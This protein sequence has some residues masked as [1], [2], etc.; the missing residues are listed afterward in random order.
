M[1]RRDFLLS[2]TALA[3]SP[4]LS[5]GQEK[6]LA[7]A[8]KGD[9]VFA[10]FE[11]GTYD[12]WTLEGNCWTPEPYSDRYFP[13]KITGYQGK[14]F[15]CT[16]HPTKGSAAKGKAVSKEFTIERPFIN[17]LIGGGN[18]P[19]EAC[20]NLTVDGKIV[21]TVTGDD[22]ATLRPVCWDVTNLLGIRANLEV[23]DQTKSSERGYIMVDN[24]M[25]SERPNTRLQ[26]L[27]EAEVRKTRAE[28][29]APC[30]G[31]A[32]TID[33]HISAIVAEG[34]LSI[35]TG[36]PFTIHTPVWVG[37]VSKPLSAYIIGKVV[38]SGKISFDA[39]FSEI[40]PDLVDISSNSVKDATLGQFVN[41]TSGVRSVSLLD[42][43]HKEITTTQT[44]R[45]TLIR[46][47]L[48][49]QPISRPGEVLLYAYGM[50]FAAAMV[51]KVTGRTFEQLIE[52][53]YGG[54]GLKSL[55]LG[56]PPGCVPGVDTP[57]GYIRDAQTKRFLARSDK[58]GPKSDW[59]YWK[60][61]TSGSFTGNTLE[62]IQALSYCAGFLPRRHR[63]Q[64]NSTFVRTRT[65]LSDKSNFTLG[66]WTRW[67]DGGYF[68]AG[69]FGAEKAN[70]QIIDEKR[71]VLFLYS[72]CTLKGEGEEKDGNYPVGELIATM[73]DLILK[74]EGR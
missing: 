73:N 8:A 43:P 47:G 14:R 21:R 59:L 37:S 17:F 16:L 46:M 23:T 12:G 30:I 54:L 57:S 62:L 51:E 35:E 64:E 27:L 5:A 28:K 3:L 38:E 24:I 32:I 44:L 25:F 48:A 42:G 45:E 66:G 50:E 74:N 31:G 53:Y 2:S 36:V 71:A 70:V 10:D 4:S 6:P 22:S 72:N 52:Q 11:S 49:L 1:N 60:C 29:D 33:G 40:R 18:H 58:E 61:G 65:L 9:L 26:K 15:L 67:R 56:L 63:G 68:H 7:S 55:R 39:R 34:T 13:G 20:L 19:N 69:S 41:H